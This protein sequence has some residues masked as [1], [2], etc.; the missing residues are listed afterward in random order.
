MGTTGRQ[1]APSPALHFTGGAGH[2][3]SRLAPSVP[4]GPLRK[5]TA[6]THLCTVWEATRKD[7]RSPPVSCC[8]ATREPPTNRVPKTMPARGKE[9]WSGRRAGDRAWPLCWS[10]PCSTDWCFSKSFEWSLP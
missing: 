1:G 5:R 7:M 4:A 3:H 10:L 6:H 8:P 2:F 9:R